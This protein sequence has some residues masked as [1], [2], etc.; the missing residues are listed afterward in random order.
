M[1]RLATLR[2][3]FG[4]T[5]PFEARVGAGVFLALALI[6]AAPAGALP[7]ALETGACSL[8]NAAPVTIAAVD[9]DFSLLLDDGRRAALSGLE[10]PGAKEAGDLHATARQRL[11]DWLVGKDAIFGSFA[12]GAD[13]WGR[14]PAA[15]FAPASTARD[16]PLVL[17]GAALLEEGLV[18]FRPDPTAAPC[19][20]AYLAAEAS[21]RENGRGLWSRPDFAP[22]DAAAP[23]ARSALAA[24]KGL[25]IVNGTVRSVGQTDRA[26]YLNFGAK[27][28]EDFAVVI[29]RRNLDMFAKAGIDLR[30]LAG[31]RVR[32]RGLIETGLGPRIEISSPTEIE[33]FDGDDAR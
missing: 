23:N 20:R 14:A 29:S 12:A 22:I 28:L 30:A 9:D 8:E 15:L 27:K 2:R 5:L 32:A 6:L 17:V 19:A 33:L 31:R 10:F 25:T 1:M 4:A 24:R 13:R 26:I 16:S 11:A 7:P 18:R 3:A 21:A